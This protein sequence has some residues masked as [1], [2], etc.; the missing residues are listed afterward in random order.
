ME[1]GQGLCINEKSVDILISGPSSTQ[2]RPQNGL[3][4]E[5]FC[6]YIVDLY[7]KRH[8]YDQLYDG[9]KASTLE[10]TKTWLALSKKYELER[11]YHC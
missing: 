5:L 4:S 3:I 1:L 11:H 2:F 10:R 6:V 9:R 7:F 8:F